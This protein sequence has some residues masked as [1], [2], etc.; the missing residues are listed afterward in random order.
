MEGG[1]YKD[2]AHHV[3]LLNIMNYCTNSA[4]SAR[5]HDYDHCMTFD[6]VF[7]DLWHRWKN[8]SP[9]DGMFTGCLKRKNA[10]YL[11]GNCVFIL[12]G[13]PLKKK[14]HYLPCLL[15]KKVHV[16]GKGSS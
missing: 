8:A 13:I 16:R 11:I 14:S 1:G 9:G 6:G 4:A 7:S 15:G 10:I 5:G 2:S 12:D 3:F